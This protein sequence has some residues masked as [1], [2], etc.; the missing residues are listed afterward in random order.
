MTKISLT[1]VWSRERSKPNGNALMHLL[2]DMSGSPL[3]TAF[4]QILRAQ[5]Y[6][7]SENNTIVLA[8]RTISACTK[9][10]Q[11]LQS[12]HEWPKIISVDTSTLISWQLKNEAWRYEEAVI[13]EPSNIFL[14][15]TG[16][17]WWFHL[18]G[19]CKVNG[20]GHLDNS[21]V[22]LVLNNHVALSWQTILGA[23][24]KINVS[25]QKGLQLLVA[26]CFSSW[27]MYYNKCDGA[28]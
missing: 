18:I 1:T 25:P 15:I 5:Q 11:K 23:M 16:R 21:S 27:N 19:Q 17:V 4:Y 20:P 12:L 26:Y 28:T 3:L 2:Q 24:G 10:L 9:K 22:L 13:A 6:N 8:I 7:D 14:P